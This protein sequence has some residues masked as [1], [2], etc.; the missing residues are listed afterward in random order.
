[1]KVS[2]LTSMILSSLYATGI[3]A[4]AHGLANTQ[5][6]I[7]LR[8]IQMTAEQIKAYQQSASSQ[9]NN[10]LRNGG[11]NVQIRS[12]AS[13]KFTKEQGITGE[14]VYIIHLNDK[15]VASKFGKQAVQ[16]T[17]NTTSSKIFSQGKAQHSAITAYTS[18]LKAKQ[19]SA[20][21]QVSSIASG[22]SAR[23]Q[24]VNAVNGFTIK[25]TQEQAE[26]VAKMANVRL[27]QRS[28]EYQLQTD[29]GPKLIQADKVWNGQTQAKT[30]FKGEGV[31][32]GVID[33][34][35]NT[36]HVSFADIGGDGFDH[37]NPWGTGNYVGECT[38]EGNES[39]CNDKL[40]GV[41]TYDV[42][43]DGYSEYF[44]GPTP[45]G[46]EDFN[47]HGS[48]TASTAAGNTLINVDFVGGQIQEAGDGDVLVEGLFPEISGVAPHAN[49]VSYQVCNPLGG[50][51]GEALVAAIED[52]ITDG[53][54][55]INFSIGG[56]DHKSPWDDSVQLAFLAANEAG[57]SIAA[58]A[59]NSGGTEGTEY[60]QQI[61]N[62]APWLLNVA[63]TTHGRTVEIDTKI[64][65]PTLAEEAAGFSQLSGGGI[66]GDSVTGIVVKAAD[67][68][69]ARCLAPF[70]AG[71][72][73]SLGYTES[74]GSDAD[75]IV[76]CERGENGRVEK[77]HNVVAGGA[78]GLILY[79][80]DSYGD[81]SNIGYTDKYAVPGIH[82]SNG[83]YYGD[84]TNNYQ[85][86]N[87]WIDGG[88]TGKYQIT[89]SKTDVSREIDEDRQ[90][91][92]AVFSSRGPSIGNPEHLVPSVSAPGVDIYAAYRDEAPFEQY[93]EGGVPVVA[94]FA[95]LSGTSMASPH[96]AGSLALLTEA[97]PDWTPA[98]RHSALQMTAEPEVTMALYSNT[99]KDE[100]FEAA[101]YR[102]GTGR[103]N[104][105][106]A[107]DA[108]LVLDESSTN[109]KM[110]DPDNGGEMHRLNVPELVNFSCEP[111]CQWIRTFTATK[112]GTYQITNEPVYNFSPN[113]DGQ[114]IQHGVD[115][116]ASPAS[117][118]LKA[119]E[120]QTVLF[121]A[122]V[123][124]AQSIFGN[125][126]VELH[127]HMLINET[128]E[129]S[130]EM[131]MPMV[132]KL[133]GG[134]LPSNLDVVAHRNQS[135][136]TS[137]EFMLPQVEAPFTRVFSA[138][139]AVPE[140][141][142][143]PKDDDHFAPW[144][145]SGEGEK[146]ELIDEATHTFNVAIPEGS[147]RF[148]VE[149]L[150]E[151]SSIG[152]SG[153]KA[154]NPHIYIGRDFNNNGEIE[155]YDE[156]ICVSD[157]NGRKNMCNIN[158]PEAGNYWVAIHNQHGFFPGAEEHDDTFTYAYGVVGEQTS[159][160]MSFAVPSTDG[161]NPVKGDLSWN[162][163][164]MA[165]GDQYYS[166]VD[167]G[168]SQTNAGN[169][170][171]IPLTLNR[172]AS[173]VSMKWQSDSQRA[174][175]ASSLTFKALPNISGN[176]R[177]YTITAQLPDGFITDLSQVEVSQSEFVETMTLEAGVLTI[178]G[179][180]KHT[181]N[182]EK[183][184]NVTTNLED[185]MCRTPDVGLG[186][187]GGYINL[188][189]GGIDPVVDAH[190]DF[191]RAGI[192]IPVSAFG[193]GY[194]SYALFNNHKYTA[195]NNLVIR[196]MGTVALDQNSVF[197]PLTMP[198]P[199]EGFLT[200]YL[201][202]L[203][204]GWGASNGNFV[205][206]TMGAP[207]SYDSGVSLAGTNNGWAIIEY[208]NARTMTYEGY[209]FKTGTVTYG[210]FGDRFD[211]ELIL[212]MNTRFADNEFEVIMAYDEVNFNGDV[213]GAVGLQG[214]SGLSNW[215]GRYSEVAGEQVAFNNL[216]QVLQE[217][218]VV[219]YDYVGPES[220]QFEVTVNGLVSS[221]MSG[222]SLT[223][224]AVSQINGMNDIEMSQTL[225][226][227]S[228]I[229]V[230]PYQDMK[231]D[232][233]S[234]WVELNVVYS[235]ETNSV[236]QISVTGE[237]IE[238]EVDAH[239][240]GS[241]VRF[242]PIADF[243]GET[244]LN[245]TVADVENPMDKATSSFNL[246]V[247]P[248]EDAPVINTVSAVA[249]NGSLTLSVDANDVDGDELAITWTQTSGTDL[250]ELP[251]TA[252]IELT[253][254]SAGSYGFDVEISDGKIS[255]TESVTIEVQAAPTQETVTPKKK[256][257]GSLGG[258]AVLMLMMAGL[259]RR[260]KR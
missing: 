82:L 7:K 137:N 228:N 252:N 90:D 204:R 89:L 201:A 168:T 116:S 253:N 211:F 220:S 143:L 62:V 78:E 235:D 239:E 11:Y 18:E 121:K 53:V 216:D 128:S 74:D 246:T 191:N 73:D 55:V 208:D 177:E 217:G 229:S 50:C 46:G 159:A 250:G 227:P 17:K 203:S 156:T 54:D 8:P 33:S 126:E 34:G 182:I 110:A 237:G 72:F 219:C 197:F 70:A 122:S 131:R 38:V 20:I 39:M 125:S 195:T 247:M 10:I 160:D 144:N 2:R 210:D 184:Y 183:S 162:I 81:F 218:L 241:T 202:P 148:V 31:I 209:D 212:N 232:E 199:A 146:A 142:T 135:S 64:T 36:D 240:A 238:S 141:V 175:E 167:I 22:N 58:A 194:S 87:T 150:S 92:L 178:S 147:K 84:W 79:N 114:F 140:T 248:S 171:I 102:A 63:A 198:I 4:S 57:I 112:D 224:T 93:I 223:A 35:V 254:V 108:G 172:G 251:S 186:S 115:V 244:V 134:D 157:S 96:V 3:A 111:E 124:D 14:H 65:N 136:A 26:Q 21:T 188:A 174:G 71:T 161:S 258:I 61:D 222:Q 155:P 1:M 192:S 98:Q 200:N 6:D 109:F 49:I 76:V 42:I 260:M 37:T 259:R 12:Q 196:P 139:K 59:G 242:R 234:D 245:V 255:V 164:S 180:Q 152:D 117:F 95:F 88:E 41:R 133:N 138:V 206:E 99:P 221:N 68:G 25:M 23:M 69:D 231:V 24:F 129:Q 52:S 113:P 77:S 145:R 169:L 187:N 130:P 119:G 19:S 101:V 153:W 32:V 151:A 16:G 243:S 13:K 60:L 94:D 257:G 215:Y 28:K 5:D 97:H 9:D 214:V 29:D 225:T 106:N 85:G 105:A 67:F 91:A 86:L 66:N 166:A 207:L 40:I 44:W 190:P 103:I 213:R 226:I 120:T 100:R 47:G 123:T 80:T 30:N 158:L 233:D 118:S 165:E 170:G 83:A 27:V 256:S 205:Q 179:T 176:E 181:G 104:V 51:P 56:V 15:P 163:E 230:S 185:A 48:H 127:S 173:D 75:I 154:G 193:T 149:I 43:T 45:Q 249:A 107:V 132:F 189:N 236:N